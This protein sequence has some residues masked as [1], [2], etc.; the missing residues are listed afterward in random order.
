MADTFVLNIPAVTADPVSWVLV[1]GFGAPLS[2]PGAG[3]LGDAAVALGDA[4]LVVLCPATQILRVSATVPVKGTAKI[5]QALP[6]A[7][8]E[9]LAGEIDEQHFAFEKAA[10]GAELP[11]AVVARDTLDGWLRQLREEGLEPDAMYAESDGVAALPN[12][13]TVLVHNDS[14][15]VRDPHGATTVADAAALQAVLELSVDKHMADLADDAIAMPL[16]L[17]IYCDADTHERNRE[18]W[19]RLRM[20]AEDVE[21]KL[22][23]AGA[24]PR[25]AGE[26][27]TGGG[28][29]LLQGDY[30]RKTDITIDWDRWRLAAA[31]FG[32][33]VVLALLAQGAEF[34]SMSRQEA[35]LDMAAAELLAETFPDAG[36]SDDPWSVLRARLGAA[37]GDGPVTTGPGLGEALDAFATAYAET[38]DIRME[39]LSYRSGVVSLQVRAPTVETLDQL[40]QSF[41]AASRGR[42]DAEIL[43][44]NPTDDAIQGRMQIKVAGG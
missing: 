20:R 10:A 2:E 44:A 30:A 7:L 16:N 36:A 22:L 42:F 3:S 29:N 32:G 6:F 40:R 39:T 8:E 25:L 19:E 28:V 21:L 41:V 33:A 15:I 43:S 17:Q 12:T 27:I 38:S 4:R 13:M 24:L 23:T 26:I 31:L 34:W 9:R 14:V 11:V 37:S 18:F 5:R 35:A 1:D